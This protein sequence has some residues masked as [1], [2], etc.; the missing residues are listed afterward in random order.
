MRMG[1]VRDK[2]TCVSSNGCT[3][4]H[5]IMGRYTVLL[6]QIVHAFRRDDLTGFRNVGD[7]ESL[8]ASSANTLL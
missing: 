2:E 1:I 5:E 4:G 8:Y 6:Q 7:H 3:Y